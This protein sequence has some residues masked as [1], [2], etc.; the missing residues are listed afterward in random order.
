MAINRYFV[1]SVLILFG[2]F[3]ATADDFDCYGSLLD[4]KGLVYKGVKI[5]HHERLSNSLKGLSN[6]V[7]MGLKSNKPHR[8]KSLKNPIKLHG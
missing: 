5:C 7:Q 6:L 2:K 4:G 3:E 1:I 8:K